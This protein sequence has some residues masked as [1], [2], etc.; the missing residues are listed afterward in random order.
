MSPRSLQGIELS[1]REHVLVLLAGDFLASCAALALGLVLLAG[2][3][4]ASDNDLAN[5]PRNAADD[6]LLPVAIVVALAIA[7]SY[8]SVHR[9]LLPS[10]LAEWKD[11]TFAI[12]AG[13]ILLLGLGALGHAVLGTSQLNATQLVVAVVVGAVLVGISRAVVRAWAQT[14]RATRVVVVGSGSITDRIAV[15]LRLQ[16][17]LTMVGRVIEAD[18][19]DPGAIGTVADLP[20]ICRDLAID[21]VIV[22]PSE[23]PTEESIHIYREIQDDVHISVVPRQ[24]ELISWRSRLTDLSGLPMIEFAP[25]HMS[26]WD[27]A[28]KRGF[29]IVVAVIALVVLSPLLLA[30]AVA[31]RTTSP[32]RALFRQERIGRGRRHFTI[33][34]FRT[35]T[36]A[37]FPPD[38]G[39]AAPS[40]E[41]TEDAGSAL[42]QVRKKQDEQHRITKVGSLLR[43]TGL[44]ELPQLW[45]V[46]VGDMSIVGPRPFIRDESD[47][48]DDWT[49][50]RFEVR[51]GMTGLWQVS[52]RNELNAEALRQ[53]DYLYV[54]SWSMWWDIKIMLDTP[55][56]MIRG[57]GAY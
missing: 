13:C 33:N 54:V 28:L 18:H 12:G 24:Y 30:I 16:K 36:A 21:R 50:R 7:G 10:S 9:A 56:A 26:R 41:P 32:G 42:W 23:R 43:K 5:F 1:D 47:H 35:M 3:S 8:R 19:V 52:G 48:L 46:L 45:N 40:P 25:P 31:V 44:D 4:G 15:Q 22:A 38:T 39:V 20:R 11:L 34:K 6:C 17:G 2:L 53:L 49:A 14:F 29:D 57:M 27:R 51:P 37:T 55:R